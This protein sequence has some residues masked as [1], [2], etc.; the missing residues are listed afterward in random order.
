MVGRACELGCSDSEAPDPPGGHLGPRPSAAHQNAKLSASLTQ[1][2][3]LPACLSLFP[4]LTV[5]IPAPS[6][7][8]SLPICYF[9]CTMSW[10]V[11]HQL[12]MLWENRK[13][14]PCV[15]KTEAPSAK[16]MNLAHVLWD[17]PACSCFLV[18]AMF[19]VPGIK[20]VMC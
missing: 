7:L 19:R 18:S 5:I 17:N 13:R 10:K 20:S 8:D 4:F 15:C 1:S 14:G 11:K 6:N 12:S 2:T 3:D 9:Y 16:G